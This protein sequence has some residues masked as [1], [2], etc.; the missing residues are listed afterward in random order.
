LWALPWAHL[1]ESFQ[2]EGR[3]QDAID[4]LRN[5]VRFAPGNVIYR[6]N[7]G[8]ALEDAGLLQDSAEEFRKADNL[9]PAWPE[10]ACI[11][12][13]Q[14][15]T[16]S[17][18]EQRDADLAL[19]YARQACRGEFAKRPDCLDVLAAA[20][21]N[22]SEFKQAIASAKKALQLAKAGGQAELAAQI[23]DRLALYC[24]QKPYRQHAAV[25]IVPQ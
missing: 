8:L 7:L 20:Y 2:R 19:A 11:T 4:P 6:L 21:A 24:Q 9:Y 17:D 14:L 5:A 25:G 3:H 22:A 12:A 13:W 16:A 18:E 23:E 15:A 1:G 10:S